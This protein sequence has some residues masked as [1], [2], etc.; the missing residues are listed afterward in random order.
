MDRRIDP[1]IA[2]PIWRLGR[3]GGNNMPA[4]AV[5]VQVRKPP[6]HKAGSH[7]EH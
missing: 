6:P 7:G 4:A 1:G 2:Q 3:N 5:E